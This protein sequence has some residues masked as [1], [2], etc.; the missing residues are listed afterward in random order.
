MILL[1]ILCA[2]ALRI[3]AAEWPKEYFNP[4]PAKDDVILPMPCGGAMAFRK[5]LI[6]N[7]G[8]LNDYSIL[9]GGNGDGSDYAE[10]TRPAYVAGSFDLGTS[11]KYYLIGKYEVSKAQ[12]EAFD[13]KC[14]NPTSDKR[15]PQNKVTWFEALSF[16]DRYNQWLLKNTAD[17]L[18]KVD[19]QYGFMRLPLEAEWEFAARGGLAIPVAQFQ[20]RVFPMA[21]DMVRFVWF[22]GSESSNGKPQ[23][24]GALKPN[25]LEIYDILGNVDEMVLDPYHLNRLDR[26]HGQAGGGVVRGGNYFT[27][28]EEIRSAQRIEVPFYVKQEPRRAETTGFR[29]VVVAPVESSRERLKAIQEA[30]QKLGSVVTADLPKSEAKATTVAA[31]G[32]ENPVDELGALSDAIQDTNVKVR[33]KNVQ[34]R[35]KIA[36][37]ERDDQRLLAGKSA[38]RLGAFLCQKMAEDGAWVDTTKALLK[39]RESEFGADDSRSKAY[40]DQLT[41]DQATLKDNLL[42]Y[43]ETILG[44]ASIYD[45]EVLG[46][47]FDILKTELHLK[48]YDG[49]VKYAEGYFKQLMAYRKK[50]EVRQSA[51]LD[52]CVAIKKTN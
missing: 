11:Q 2:F 30:W 40:R 7:D 41:N 13:P 22:D 48:K 44:A 49:L 26:L 52:S 17:K 1:L 45:D 10:H 51:W 47:Q 46:S 24:I 43:S 29:L 33:L 34:N 42:Y 28:R 8:P 6:P 23:S 4:N 15:L 3:D 20:E 18:P 39:R 35:I 38:L 27:P 14:D 12:Y 50:P 36:V 19:Q 37:Q 31:H 32:L 9:L 21:E 16:A 25:P 5:V